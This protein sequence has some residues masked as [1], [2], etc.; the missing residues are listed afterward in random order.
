[1]VH[2][3]HTTSIIFL[4]F[5][6]THKLYIKVCKMKDLLLELSWS[7]WYDL[8]RKNYP[9]IQIKVHLLYRWGIIAIFTIKYRY[10]K[11]IFAFRFH[12][13]TKALVKL[14]LLFTHEAFLNACFMACAFLGI[15][16]INICH[17]SYTPR[18]SFI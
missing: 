6:I 1:M 5:V 8:L 9:P 17:K 13:Q 11:N 16:K 2:F 12:S 7:T 18:D 4:I 3:N 10:F 15:R 14:S